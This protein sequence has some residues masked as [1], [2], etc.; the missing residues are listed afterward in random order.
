MWHLYSLFLQGIESNNDTL[1]STRLPVR[2]DCLIG[3]QSFDRALYTQSSLFRGQHRDSGNESSVALCA[4]E[5][6]N[7]ELLLLTSCIDVSIKYPCRRSIFI[8]SNDIAEP[9]QPLDVNTLLNVHVIEESLYGSLLQ[10]LRKLSQI[11]TGSYVSNT[12][13][14]GGHVIQSKL[15]CLSNLW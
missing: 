4:N 5:M 1:T 7:I 6:L 14:D 3:N 15:L 13:K 11:R 2:T 9:M 10:R 12:L 8:H